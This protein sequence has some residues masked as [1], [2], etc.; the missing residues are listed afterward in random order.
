[1]G[2]TLGAVQGEGRAGRDGSGKARGLKSLRAL[3]RPCSSAPPWLA[4][5]RQSQEQTE[6]KST[7]RDGNSLELRWGRR[8]RGVAVGALSCPHL[9]LTLLCLLQPLPWHLT[10]GESG[11]PGPWERVL[12][13]LLCC[14]G[15]DTYC[16]H[17]PELPLPNPTLS[18]AVQLR[19]V[20]SG[21]GASLLDLGSGEVGGASALS[22]M[23]QK[24][25]LCAPLQP[26][27]VAV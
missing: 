22:G 4:G 16:H 5:C 1:M 17:L 24:Q 8:P 27:L 18:P 14:P 23:F 10:L 26:V 12:R 13:P 9:A 7:G 11:Q 20:W 6:G 15:S 19:A 3:G 25:I 2:A 21:A